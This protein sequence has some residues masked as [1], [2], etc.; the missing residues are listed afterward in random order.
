[1]IRTGR[2]GERDQWSLTAGYSGGG[3]REVRD[4]SGAATRDE[5]RGLVA[6]AFPDAGDARVGNFTAQLWALR[7]RIAVGDLVVLPLKTTSAVAIGRITGDYRYLDEPDPDRRHARPVKWLATDIAR[8]AIRQDLLYSLGAFLTICEI[9]RN[10][11]AWRL[12]R[13]AE[14]GADPGARPSETR[15][16]PPP[17]AGTAETSEDNAASDV[18][19]DLI[20]LG[21]RATDRLQDRLI[22]AFAGHRM[23]DL[24]AAVLEAEGFR[25][26]TAPAGPDG[27]VDVLAGMGP[28]G[29]D[30]PR[31]V[32]QVKSEASP[33][34]SEVVQQLLGALPQFQATQGLLVAW[35]GL[36]KP[37]RQLL[38]TQYFQVR[39][40]EATQL[41]EAVLRNYA[42]LPSGVRSDLPLKQIWVPVEDSG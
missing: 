35:G 36:T 1:M 6:E 26:T 8:T 15:N 29:L 41:I 17:S 28:L 32:V 16:E 38:T 12:A 30:A 31:I 39:V 23:Q 7:S 19:T 20:D 21:Q 34:K 5:V 10:D 4:L 42:S 22:E 2:A 13:I 14:K 33:V 11:G 40:W 37:A 3:F 24:V 27:G 25:T 18:G 9:K